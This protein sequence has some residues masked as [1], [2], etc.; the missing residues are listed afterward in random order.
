[1]QFAKFTVFTFYVL[2]GR[3]TN[4]SQELTKTFYEGAVCEFSDDYSDSV[5][6]VSVNVYRGVHSTLYTLQTKKCLYIN[7][8]PHKQEI[9]M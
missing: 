9:Q 7:L 3:P 6:R 5:L 8:P 2:P 1:V 4:V